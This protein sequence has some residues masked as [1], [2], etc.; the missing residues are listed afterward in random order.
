MMGGKLK[1]R[2]NRPMPVGAGTP[3]LVLA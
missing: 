2:G 3:P 1:P